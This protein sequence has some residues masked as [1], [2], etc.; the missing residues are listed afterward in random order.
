MSH[1]GRIEGLDPEDL[2]LGPT[3]VIQTPGPPLGWKQEPEWLG[4]DLFVGFPCYKQTNPAT[5][6][7]LVAL[8]L[9]LGKDRVRFDM[10]VGDA[11]IYHARNE[12]AMKFLAT[13]AQWLLFIDDDMIPPIGRP[14][15]LR[16]MCRLPDSY[17]TA[18]TA[19]HVAHR[20]IGHGADIVGATYFARHP[21]GRAVNSLANDEAYRARA[22]SFHDG[23]MPCDWIGTGCLLIHR[24]VF[25]KMQ[26]QFP[27]LN[28]TNPEMPFNFFQPENDGR[29]EDIAF[30]A[31]AVECGFQPNVDTMLHALHVG[32][33]VYGHH[34]SA[35]DDIL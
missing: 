21:R 22:A 7:C 18:P 19:L 3:T 29:G 20:L 11:M 4:R 24:R 33:G 28:P 12:L 2:D 32:H 30:C 9:D 16:A 14:D 13:P 8:A 15:F 6:W 10:Q 23:I 35:I 17:P 25:E 34:T 5:A 26:T 27:D 1:T 31:R